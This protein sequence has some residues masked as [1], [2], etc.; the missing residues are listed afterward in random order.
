VKTIQIQWIPTARHDLS[1]TVS[2]NTD[3][4]VFAPRLQVED[5]GSNV[6]APVC[7]RADL[8]IPGAIETS[9]SI[10]PVASASAIEIQWIPKRRHG[11]QLIVSLNVDISV[12]S[13]NVQVREFYKFF[14]EHVYHRVGL[15]ILQAVET[16][17]PIAALALIISLK[18]IQI[19]WI[20][21]ARHDGSPT[22]CLNAD[23]FVLAP[24]LQVEDFGCNVMEPVCCRVEL[25]ISGAIET[26][27]PISCH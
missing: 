16:S 8:C 15:C 14:G 25:C 7:C 23:F 20:P 9:T 26:W 11:R 27:S 21:T 1:L 2:L 13:P 22:A 6:M 5:V 3:F 19:Q 10:P 4:F 12:C 24:R 18:T 17:I